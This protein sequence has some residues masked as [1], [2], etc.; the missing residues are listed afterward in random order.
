MV[1]IKGIVGGFLEGL[2]HIFH[3]KLWFRPPSARPIFTVF[4]YVL[5]VTVR[6]AGKGRQVRMMA[7]TGNDLDLFREN[8]H[9]VAARE[10]VTRAPR[11][12]N[13]RRHLVSSRHHRFE[14]ERVKWLHFSDKKKM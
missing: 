4:K 8:A 12:K 14:F 10:C 9:G 6:W 5:R 7:K 1:T 13:P 11:G 2:H 3:G